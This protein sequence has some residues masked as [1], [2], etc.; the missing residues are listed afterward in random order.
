MCIDRSKSIL[1][2][3]VLILCYISH[4]LFFDI[5]KK[6]HIGVSH[7]I[8]NKFSHQNISVKDWI[9]NLVKFFKIIL[10][11]FLAWIKTSNETLV[12]F[13]NLRNQIRSQF[14]G[15][16]DK[17]V[18]FVFISLFTAI[19]SF[20][21]KTSNKTDHVP[22]SEHILDS[23]KLFFKRWVYQCGISFVFGLW[24]I[25]IILLWFLS[26]TEYIFL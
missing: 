23:E 7:P 13:Y 6:R 11:V 17:K 8:S 4:G 20:I 25:L 19:S 21:T 26:S 16:Y 24:N 1:S 18:C 14:E 2:R 3:C 15:N 22:T 12:H 5:P 10:S 9:N